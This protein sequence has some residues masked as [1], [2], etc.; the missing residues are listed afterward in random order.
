MLKTWKNARCAICQRTVCGFVGCRML[1][2]QVKC[3]TYLDAKQF[4]SKL[5][6]SVVTCKTLLL[7]ILLPERSLPGYFRYKR[8]LVKK[9]C[10]VKGFWCE[11]FVVQ[12][13]LGVKGYCCKV[14][15]W[16]GGWCK[17]G[18]SAQVVL[19]IKRCFA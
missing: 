19:L 13:V 3:G 10:G 18:F 12:E 4:W 8:L 9:L 7:F 5:Q 15:W 16:K 6:K 11:R 1:K 17:Q 2:T 14:A